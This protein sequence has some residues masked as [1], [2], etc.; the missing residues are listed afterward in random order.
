MR[1][2]YQCLQCALH[3]S[4]I[5][6]KAA[7]D[8]RNDEVAE[9][10]KAHMKTIDNELDERTKRAVEQAREKGAST[11]LNVLPLK[12]HGFTSTNMNSEMP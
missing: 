4:D 5:V 1:S 2:S 7:R 11:W 8:E 6:T 9:V 12:D 10:K 3:Y